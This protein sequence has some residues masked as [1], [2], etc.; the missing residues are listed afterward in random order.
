MNSSGEAAWLEVVKRI[1]CR[2]GSSRRADRHRTTTR[3]GE[4]R[5]RPGPS[6]LALTRWRSGFSPMHR[7]AS[8]PIHHF[9]QP[10]LFHSR[11]VSAP[12]SF[13]FLPSQ[14][15]H[16]RPR[17]WRSAGRRY[18]ESRRA[19]NSATPRLRSVGRP[20]QPGRRLTALPRDGF[21]P[22]PRAAATKLPPLPQSGD[23]CAGCL[24]PVGQGSRTSR[25][26][27]YDPLRDATSI[28]L[29]SRDF[30]YL[31]IRLI[32]QGCYLFIT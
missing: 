12:G 31:P 29:A 20:A 22:S 28:N 7:T 25:Q 24:R 2:H 1:G 15:P 32:P 4:A 11:G 16:P 18:P 27:F 26:R 23:P 13:S 9:K 17:G 10:S 19:R 14:L 3:R 8:F 30:P 5:P 6:A 21:G